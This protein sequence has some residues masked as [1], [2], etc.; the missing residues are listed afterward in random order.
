[1][2]RQLEVLTAAAALERRRLLQWIVAWAGLSAMWMLELN[3]SPSGNLRV[4]ELAA[5]ELNR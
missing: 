1:M 5:A 3:L 4:A 2:A